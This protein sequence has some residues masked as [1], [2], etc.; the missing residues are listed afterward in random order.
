MF[1]NVKCVD[2]LTSIKNIIYISEN[3]F[4]INMLLVHLGIYSIREAVQT[5]IYKQWGK[6]VEKKI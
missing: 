2:S 1:H 4:D 5:D 6:I 3:V